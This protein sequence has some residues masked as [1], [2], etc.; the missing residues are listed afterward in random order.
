MRGL[1]FLAHRIPYPPD[2]GDRIRSFH[3][4]QHLASRFRIYLGCFSDGDVQQQSVKALGALC[5][6]VFCLAL[7]PRK[8]YF[9]TFRASVRNTS[10]S[11][12]IYFDV[13][14]ARWVR[15]KIAQTDVHDALIFCSAMFPYLRDFRGQ[16][17][18]VTDLVDVDS[19]KW[20]EYARSSFWPLSAIYH[21]EQRKLFELETNAVEESDTALFVSRAEANCFARLAPALR[22]RV[23][24][25]ENGVDLAHFNKG[26]L[27]PNPF[28]RTVTPIVFTGMMNYWPNADAVNWFAR[29][30]MPRFQRIKKSAEFWI[31]GAEPNA[32]VR[33]LSRLN[34]VRV[35]GA[36]ADVRPYLAHSACVV[37]PLRIARGIQNKVL[38]AMAM[39]KVV[40]VT[41]QALEGLSAVPDRELLV[42]S[43][44]EDFLRHLS[45]SLS[46]KYDGMGALA[47]TRVEK[48]YE[49]PQKMALLDDIL[50][51]PL[52]HCSGNTEEST[53]LVR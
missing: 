38:E 50:A 33:Q 32:G 40:I 23:R 6:E 17:R 16:L 30:V 53:E 9:A 46:G 15:D 8:K 29:E 13:R 3:I 36:V 12:Q 7:P 26:I 25:L 22:P 10:I 4:L 21:R 14:M 52:P 28:P 49:W 45:E 42:A 47:R 1:L 35:T 37:A 18:L 27:H 34:G 24:S 19:Q 31:V 48:D 5:A 41:P 43:T 39:A 20:A 11:E 2:K 51:K 44:P